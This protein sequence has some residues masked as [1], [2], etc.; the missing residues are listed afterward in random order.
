MLGRIMSTHAEIVSELN[1]RWPEQQIAPSLARIQALVE[2]LGDPQRSCPV[3]QLTG[4]NGKGSTAIIVDALLRAQGLRTGRYASPHLTD[5]T[6]R[7]CIDGEPVSQGRFDE[8]YADIAPYVQMVDDQAIEGVAMTFF[9]VLTGLAFAIFADAPVDV[10]V[11]EVGMGGSWD[12]TNAADADVAVV[13][14]IDVDHTEYLGETPAEI[15]VEKAGIIKVGSVPVLAGQAAEVAQVLMAR[16]AEVGVAPLREGI[17]FGLLDRTP[18]VGGQVIRINTVAG[19]VGDL[20]LPLYGEHMARNT[21]LAVAAVEALSGGRPLAPDLISDALA[22]VEAPAR[23]ELVRTS[24]P[25]VLDT[26]HNPHGARATMAA[27]GEAYGFAPLIGVVGMMADKDI[28]GTLAVLAED[29]AT[30]LCTQAASA[31]AVPAD[32]LAEIARGLVGE[33]RVVVVPRLDDAIEAAIALAD[34]AGAGAGVLVC[35]SVALAGQ[36]RGMLVA[37]T[38]PKRPTVAVAVGDS[39]DDDVELAGWGSMDDDDDSDADRL[40][41][42]DRAIDGHWA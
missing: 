2:L 33:D 14:P 29:M 21:A 36:A 42:D 40:D 18:A 4:T 10:M 17:D 37:A 12:D 23:T 25:V 15:A 38:S 24:P 13:T 26:C 31:R 9:E 27:M 16:C 3:I 19:S 35:G 7:I 28:E 30:I 34:E 41:G 22:V 6:E 11:P 39:W 8:A 20:H 32:D 5:L 1:R